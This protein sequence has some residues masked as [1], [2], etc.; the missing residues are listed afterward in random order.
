M[1][2]FFMGTLFVSLFFI[3]G[4]KTDLYTGLDEKEAN[5]MMALLIYNHIP[6]VKKTDKDGI[7]LSVEEQ[8]FVDAV[9]VLRLHGLPGRE[10][11]T[12][13]DLF[14]GGQ[15]VSSPEQEYAKLSYLSAQSLEKMLSA[16]DGV[17][18]AEVSV[19]EQ[20]PSEK[21]VNHPASASVFIKYSPE[22]NI[23]VREAEIRTLIRNAI[24]GLSPGKIALTLQR[25]QYQYL[26][27]ARES[28]TTEGR[29]TWGWLSIVITLTV[30]LTGMA[31]LLM[32]RRRGVKS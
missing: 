18:L 31:V 16:M 1:K 32:K 25:A 11:V 27:S 8:K 3:T 29:W 26:S 9:E 7:T 12:I 21:D 19:A 17:I 22:V 10:I 20:R 13:S 4:C 5:E 2:K 30:G 15:L 28:A 23:P 24:P 14:P 6:V